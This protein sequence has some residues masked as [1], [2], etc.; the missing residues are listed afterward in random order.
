MQGILAILIGF[1][2]LYY[3]L[4]FLRDPIFAKKY[5]HSSPKAYLW[6]SL[7]GEEKA[8]KIASYIFAPMGILFG[9]GLILLGVYLLIN[10]V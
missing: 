8:F 1:V 5:I 9:I 3:S 7:F 2:D 10:K 4:R 6:R